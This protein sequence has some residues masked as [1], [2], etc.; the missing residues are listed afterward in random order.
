MLVASALACSGNA[1]TVLA[2]CFTLTCV[3]LGNCTYISSKDRL[4]HYSWQLVRDALQSTMTAS[5]CQT[6]LHHANNAMQ[7]GHITKFAVW[8]LPRMSGCMSYT[9]GTQWEKDTREDCHK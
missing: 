8:L 4:Q 9:E 6:A 1:A 7:S 5:V 3:K 2:S